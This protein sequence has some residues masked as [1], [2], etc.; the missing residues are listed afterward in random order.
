MTNYQTKCEV[1]AVQAEKIP[2]YIE[3][4]DKIFN[5]IICDF[6][7]ADVQ[8]IYLGLKD[9]L[10]DWRQRRLEEMTM[11]QKKLIEEVNFEKALITE[12]IK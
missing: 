12:L 7:H 9:K 6:S 8:R 1:Q 4:V 5:T 10:V 3:V 2:E 11:T